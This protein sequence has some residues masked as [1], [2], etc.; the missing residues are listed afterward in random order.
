MYKDATTEEINTIMQKAAD[1]AKV[2]RKSTLQSRRDLMYR[3][4]TGLEEKLP[5]LVQTAMRETNL[6]ETRLKG[7]VGRTALQM[8]QYGDEC[9]R[10]DWMDIR[11]NTAGYQNVTTDIRKM[12]IALGP[13][14]IFGASNFPFAFS[15]G[16]GDTACALAAGCPVV[17]KAHPAHPDTSQMVADIIHEAV[18]SQGLPEG[19]FSHV[20]GISYEVGKSLVMH[21]ETSAV[22]FTGSYRGGKQLFDWATQRD[23]PIPVF[24]EMGSTNPVFLLPEKLDAEA[25]QV[26]KDYAS[27]ITTGAGQFCTKPGLIFGVKGKGLDTFISVLSEEIEKIAPQK[28]LHPGIAKSYKVNRTNAISQDDVTVL[29][30]PTI[31]INSPEGDAVVAIV[32]AKT[33]I[34]NKKLHQEVFGPYSLLIQCDDISQMCQV[35]DDLEGQLTATIIGSEDEVARNTE[36]VDIIK[37]KCGRILLNGVPTGVTVCQAMHHGGPYPASTDSRFTSVGSDG[38]KRFTRPLCFQ[39][40]PESLLPDELKNA[41]P[42]K[43]WRLVNGEHTQGSL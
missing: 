7:E 6:P 28:M 37:N 42:L 14:V 27:S 15:T 9:C 2:Y 30:P 20:T 25:S 23:V 35:A 1:A 8:R 12:E 17:V 22:G 4:A 18:K 36:L 16:G 3:I 21:K 43:I 34:N 39:N 32:D 40:F 5:E 24:S 11:I 26:A 38:I 29:T 19:V 13:V 10:A 41:N 31:E 33:F